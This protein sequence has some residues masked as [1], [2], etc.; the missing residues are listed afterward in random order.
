[1]QEAQ[2]P[3]PSPNGALQ[4]YQPPLLDPHGQKN[5]WLLASLNNHLHLK[6]K[7]S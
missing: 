5:A 4:N 1:M 6:L 7:F 3:P 2:S